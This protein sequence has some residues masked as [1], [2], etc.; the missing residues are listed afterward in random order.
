MPTPRTNFPFEI[1]T[2]YPIFFAFPSIDTE[3]A[4][5]LLHEAQISKKTMKRKAY[6]FVWRNRSRIGWIS[7]SV[8]E[9]C[10]H[11]ENAAS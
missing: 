1:F 2:L 11:G 6:E 8:Y 4:A 9:V 10:D 7:D 3:R 5:I